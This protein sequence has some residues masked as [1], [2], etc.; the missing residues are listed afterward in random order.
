[1]WKTKE[2]DGCKL[3]NI[4][5]KSETSKAKWLME[6][7]TNPAF[8]IHLEIFSNLVGVQKGD[9]QGKNLIFMEKNF[10]LRTMKISNPFYKE[11]LKSL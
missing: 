2:N 1:M 10:I 3:V 6:I 5:V 11:A 8:R 7:A 4:Q 9:N